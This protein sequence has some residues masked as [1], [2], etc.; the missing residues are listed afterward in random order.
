MPNNGAMPIVRRRGVRR[1]ANAEQGGG[2][3]QVGQCRVRRWANAERRWANLGQC[4]VITLRF[5]YISKRGLGCR[6]YL[7]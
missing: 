7:P 5:K 6:V 4:R 2:A 1:W 3:M